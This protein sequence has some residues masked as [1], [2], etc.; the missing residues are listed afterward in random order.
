ML[1]LRVVAVEIVTLPLEPVPKYDVDEQ[2]NSEL[3]GE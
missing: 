2:S 3:G 1:A